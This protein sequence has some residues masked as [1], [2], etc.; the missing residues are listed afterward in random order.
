MIQS[1]FDVTQEQTL[2]TE[3]PAEDDGEYDVIE[4]TE[5]SDLEDEE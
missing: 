1:I 2:D 5:E 4:I 3:P